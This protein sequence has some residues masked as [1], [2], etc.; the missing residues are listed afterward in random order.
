MRLTETEIDEKLA[1]FIKAGKIAEDLRK[2]LRVADIDKLDFVVKP[3]E[4]GFTAAIKFNSVSK[5]GKTNQYGDFVRFENHSELFETEAVPRSRDLRFF[6]VADA[7]E[8]AVYVES[9]YKE[10]LEEEKKE[11]LKKYPSARFFDKDK[12]PL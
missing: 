1:E 11:V 12:N 2:I 3:A 6:V 7:T 5:D 8:D 9:C 4:K 10:D